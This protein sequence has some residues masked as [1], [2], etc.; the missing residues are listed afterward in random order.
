METIA[1]E[2]ADGKIESRLGVILGGFLT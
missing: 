2:A 1:R